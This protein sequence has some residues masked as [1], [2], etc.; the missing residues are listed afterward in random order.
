MSAP[1]VGAADGIPPGID[2]PFNRPSLV[3][4]ELRYMSEAIAAGRISGDGDFSRRC[5]ELLERELGAPRVLL[6]TSCTHA[7]EMC[8]LLLDLAPG[9]EVIVPSFTFVSTANAFAL[10]GARPVFADV[11]PDTLNL[12]ES[13]LPELIGPRTRAIVAVHY[14]GVG[15]EMAAILALAGRH[16]LAVVED[17]AHGL[18]GK[19]G[20]TKLGTFG[21]LATL[22]FHETKNVTCG[23]GGALIV[24]DARYLERAETVRQKGTNRSQF[25]RGMVDKYSW[26]DLGSSYLPSDMLAAFLLAQLEA[27]DR[28]QAARRRLWQR[29]EQELASWAAAN[30]ARLPVVPPGCEQPFHLFYLLLPSLAA[31]QALIAHLRGHGIL[32]A[33][34]YVPLHLSAYGRQAAARWRD[35]P[36]AADV[37]DRL[38]RL[39]LFYD[40]SAA[41]QSRVIAAVQ[42]FQP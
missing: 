40:L 26:V 17:N 36:V 38:V 13:L 21:G 32:A 41:D 24:N 42:A 30:G 18:F 4:D 12:D 3:G 39:P 28:I 16:G 35:C 15:C 1:P 20:G 19:H 2:I 11:R 23:E 5:H 7:L 10:R 14:A 31:R 29:Y 34:H 25:F 9:D 6:T 37:A 8:S 33:F 27:R 22:S